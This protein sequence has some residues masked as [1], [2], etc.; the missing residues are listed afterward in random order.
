MTAETDICAI[1]ILFSGTVQGVGFRFTARRLAV[2]FAVT[3]YVKNLAN[4]NVGVWAE[5]T[6]GE[7]EQFIDSIQRAFAGYIR[8]TERIEVTP[9]KGYKRFEIA[10]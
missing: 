7:I 4:G 2:D 3:G 8:D 6:R 10:F 1:K 9:T 5:G